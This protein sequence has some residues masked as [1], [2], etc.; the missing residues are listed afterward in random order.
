MSSLANSRS[1]A[2]DLAAM[3]RTAWQEGLRATVRR[4]A[5]A[6]ANW[7][8]AR[9]LHQLSDWQL[10]DIGIAREQIEIAVRRKQVFHR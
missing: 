5:R 3:A 6:Y 9:Q 10:E 1:Q 8:T 2:S 7:Y 4:A